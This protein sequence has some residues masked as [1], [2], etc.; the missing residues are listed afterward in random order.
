MLCVTDKCNVSRPTDLILSVTDW[1]SLL[2]ICYHHQT[3]ICFQCWLKCF[4]ISTDRYPYELWL[5]CHDCSFILCVTDMFTVST[6]LILKCH[7]FDSH[8]YWYA[9]ITELIYALSA[10]WC[11]SVWA[12]IDIQMSIDWYTIIAGDCYFVLID[13]SLIPI[14]LLSELNDVVYAISISEH[15][16]APHLHFF[17]YIY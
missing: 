8:R 13:A 6:D 17:S 2:L 15:W 5:V 10:D 12:L 7:W 14:K 4:G 16:Y 3:D 11:A 9:I 1:Y